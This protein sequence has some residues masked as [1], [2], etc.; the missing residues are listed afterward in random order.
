[1]RAFR[2]LMSGRA[3]D[4]AS[5]QRLILTIAELRDTLAVPRAGAASCLALDTIDFAIRV[6]DDQ[7]LCLACIDRI[8]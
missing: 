2:A 3:P 4:M 1:M 8:T 5:L 6:N 7:G